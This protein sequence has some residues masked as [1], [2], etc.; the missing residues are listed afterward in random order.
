MYVLLLA[1]FLN[2]SDDSEHRTNRTFPNEKPIRQS[3]RHDFLEI[4]E[5]IRAFVTTTTVKR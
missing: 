4:I 3:S 1:I 5:I 2:S